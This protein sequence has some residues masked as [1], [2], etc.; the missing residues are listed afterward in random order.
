MSRAPT[1]DPRVP[2][3]VFSPYDGFPIQ[4]LATREAYRDHHPEL[5]WRF[6]PWTGNPRH[7]SDIVS[8]PKGFLIWDYAW[9]PLRA[10]AP[11][12]E[13]KSIMSL[14][15]CCAAEG[16]LPI[17][18]ITFGGPEPEDAQR[19]PRFDKTILATEADPTG[20]SARTPGAKLDAGKV[21]P[22]LCI[23]GFSRALGAVAEVTTRGAEKYADNSWMEV[24][25]GAARYM[26]G[27]ARHT[28]ALGRGETHDTGPG[29]TGCL[30]KA[31]MI[32]NLLASLELDLRRDEERARG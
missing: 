27:F 28:L 15:E 30:H 29:G 7:A 24:P 9:G 5:E 2:L 32:W 25:D 21:R 12:P 3:L 19:D 11:A 23:G 20:R 1:V 8:D 26:E 31:Q 22:W 16:A 18:V 4:W 13:H 14:D 6:N 17:N 10:A